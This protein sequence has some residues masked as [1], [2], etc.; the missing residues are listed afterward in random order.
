MEAGDTVFPWE[1]EGARSRV[2]HPRSIL[3]AR[4]G[5]ADLQLPSVCCFTDGCGY[6]MDET[7]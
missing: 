1:W 4:F 3:R 2:R 6:G 7:F 5:T